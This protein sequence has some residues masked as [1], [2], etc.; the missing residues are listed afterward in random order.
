MWVRRGIPLTVLIIIIPFPVSCETSVHTPCIPR[1]S[2]YH[3]SDHPSPTG[4][5]VSYCFWVFG[6]GS[7]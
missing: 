1:V 6:Q 3:A 2:V 5:S 4:S 7:S